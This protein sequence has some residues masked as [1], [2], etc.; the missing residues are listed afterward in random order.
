[1][2]VDYRSIQDSWP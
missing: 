2:T 1:M